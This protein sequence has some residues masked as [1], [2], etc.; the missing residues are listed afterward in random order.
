MKKTILAFGIPAIL[1]CGMLAHFSLLGHDIYQSYKTATYISKQDVNFKT[2]NVD[3]LAR[4]VADEDFS[5]ESKWTQIQSSMAHLTVDQKESRLESLQK[6]DSEWAEIR[7]AQTEIDA[8]TEYWRNNELLA[9]NAKP[10][11]GKR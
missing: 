10:Q 4:I 1:V 9:L 7:S 11:A 6:T 5:S 8:Q 2:S 3:L